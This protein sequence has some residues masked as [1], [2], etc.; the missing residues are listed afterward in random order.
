MYVLS[1]EDIIVSKIIRLSE[2]DFQDIDFL[3]KKADKNLIKEI[4]KEVIN[5]NDLFESKKEEFKRK[6]KVFRE[7]YDV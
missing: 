5:R 4:I 3:I 7:R 6:L 2:K 1:I